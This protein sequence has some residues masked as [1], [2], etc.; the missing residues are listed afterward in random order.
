[1]IACLTEC[2]GVGRWTAEMFLMFTLGRPDVLPLDDFRNS[3]RLPPDYGLPEMPTSGTRILRGAL[4]TVSNHRQLVS[5]E[6]GRS[7]QA[8]VNHLRNI[9][10]GVREFASS[11]IPAW[12]PSRHEAFVRKN[13]SYPGLPR[14][15]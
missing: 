12:A 8:A 2:R 10:Q 3:Q 7:C 1:M 13:G 4:A 11:S 5:V 6:G 15:F 14:A 9:A